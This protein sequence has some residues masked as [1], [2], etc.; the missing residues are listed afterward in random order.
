MGRASLGRTGPA[1]AQP[2]LGTGWAQGGDSLGRTLAQLKPIQ[3]KEE[4]GLKA[5]RSSL[6]GRN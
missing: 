3:T 6:V 5:N 2:Q 4:L 1:Q